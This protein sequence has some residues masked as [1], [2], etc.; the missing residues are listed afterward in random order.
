MPIFT[1]AVVEKVIRVSTQWVEADSL[2][3][4]QELFASGYG[5]FEDNGANGI[6]DVM[7]RTVGEISEEEDW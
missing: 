1:T 4:A 6:D 5:E 7:F 3:E 2:E